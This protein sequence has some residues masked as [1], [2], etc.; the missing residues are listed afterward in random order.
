MAS[1]T[2]PV[3]ARTLRVLDVELE[4]SRK[5]GRKLQQILWKQMPHFEPASFKATISFLLFLRAE[6][7][8]TSIRTLAGLRLVD[9]SLALV[10]V[11]VEK[12][13]NGQYILLSDTEVAF[14]FLQ[15]HALRE[16]RDL[17]ELKDIAPELAPNY[18]EAFLTDLR[19]AHDRA[20]TRI[21]PD[22]ST[23]SRYGRGSDWV[24]IGLSKRAAAIDQELSRR[25]PPQVFKSTQVLYQLTYKKGAIF[26]HGM[27][28]SLGRSLETMASD[29]PEGANGM[30]SVNV[31]VR[32]KDKH[33]KVA[34]D[35]MQ[36]ANLA[37][38]CLILFIGKV[39]SRRDYLDW[40]AAFKDSYSADVKT[41]N[42]A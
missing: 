25:F 24:Q 3:S 40:V 28:G 37:A 26:L 31:G 16:W 4:A 13:I 38:I 34:V 18:S 41:A 30:V 5:L 10:G 29:N 20:K 11:M 14:D 9:D 39:F 1:S 35:A 6:R 22:G 42:T 12:V 17:E 8:F 33:P 21:H 15:F 2:T 7:T 27:F 32:I 19:A 23:S 36:A